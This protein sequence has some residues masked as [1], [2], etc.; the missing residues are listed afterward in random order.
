MAYVDEKGI[1][2]ALRRK[3]A[4][5]GAAELNLG[6]VQSAFASRG[7]MSRV[8]YEKARQMREMSPKR[9]DRAKEEDVES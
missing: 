4:E 1:D 2:P 3:Y 6:E 9:P 8:M 7:V 5:M